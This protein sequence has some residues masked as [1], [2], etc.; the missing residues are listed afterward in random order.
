MLKF[1]LSLVLYCWLPLAGLA[2]LQ[3][4]QFPPHKL[5]KDTM[6]LDMSR[7]T[8]RDFAGR[9]TGHEG[10]QRAA[11]MVAGKLAAFDFEYFEQ[12]DRAPD[13]NPYFLSVPYKGEQLRDAHFKVGKAAFGFGTGF[14]PGSSLPKQPLQFG[15]I[16]FVGF[17]QESVHY[18]DFN[19]TSIKDKWVVAMPGRVDSLGKWQVAELRQQ[20]RSLMQKG[21]AGV[22]LVNPNFDK[23]VKAVVSR[24]KHERV[25]LL[26]TVDESGETVRQPIPL[27]LI[28]PKAAKKLYKQMRINAKKQYKQRLK[29]KGGKPVA[30]IIAG[31]LEVDQYVRSFDAPNVIGFVRGEEK[32]DEYVLLSAHLD[33]LGEHDG[34]IY[35]GADDNGSGSAALL[36]IARELS[37]W[38]QAGIRP[39]RSI[40]IVWFSG[41]ENG[42]LG[43]KWLANHAPMPTDMITTNINV[44]MIGRSDS[45]HKP[46]Q[47]YIYVIGADRIS[48]E[49]H[50]VGEAVNEQCCQLELDYTY[51]DPKDPNR[52]YYRSDHYN[53]AKQGI[54]SVFYF[55]GVHADYHRPT[56]TMDKI[57][58]NRMLYLTEYILYTGWELANRAERLIIN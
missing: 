53:F 18:S 19:G 25:S 23:E 55:S 22:I 12:P 9:G 52:Y 50:E 32:P 16:V 17:G 35:Y 47:K 45:R 57:D 20:Y 27:L 30:A 13:H 4:T 26:E 37:S 58:F 8:S 33:H 29:D 41:E 31:S 28:S 39:R 36:S 49:L 7:L 38:L 34:E 56:D 48:R 46:D 5:N 1:G 51:N 10:Y 44:D 14:Y 40:A 3:S 2:Q 54:P 11:E 24:L 21:A 6:L 43:S 15:E 42:L